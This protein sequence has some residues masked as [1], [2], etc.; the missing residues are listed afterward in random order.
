MRSAFTR[1]PLVNFDV[2]FQT[3]RKLPV[4]IFLVT[5]FGF[6]GLV[7]RTALFDALGALGL[8]AFAALGAFGLAALRALRAA[9][10]VARLAAF[11]AER[12]LVALRVALTAIL[13]VLG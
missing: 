12:G 3:L 13:L 8:V 9:M 5:R 6:L 2:P 10:R 1:P 11:F 4:C 7:R